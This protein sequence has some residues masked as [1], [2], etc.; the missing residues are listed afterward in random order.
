MGY[1]HNN[2]ISLNLNFELIKLIP[3]AVTSIMNVKATILKS[4][5][6]AYLCEC[7][8]T[9]A[10]IIKIVQILGFISE[11]VCSANM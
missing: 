5:I 3:N 2:T 1:K 7:F 8:N 10:K 4:T 11:N 9:S 6:N